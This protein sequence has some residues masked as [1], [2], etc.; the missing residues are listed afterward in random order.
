MNFNARRCH[1]VPRL[2]WVRAR[3]ERSFVLLGD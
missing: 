3:L 2:R 1:C